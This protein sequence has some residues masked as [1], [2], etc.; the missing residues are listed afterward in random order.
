MQCCKIL[1]LLHQ[2]GQVQ[3]PA[4]YEHPLLGL[5]RS[6]PCAL[7]AAP[8]TTTTSA[9]PAAARTT[10]GLVRTMERGG[11]SEHE[12]CLQHTLFCFPFPSLPYL[13]PNTA[14]LPYTFLFTS[15]SHSQLSPGAKSTSPP[16]PFPA[17]LPALTR[18]KVHFAQCVQL[19]LGHQGL[20]PLLE[21][22]P[23]GG[24]H[25]LWEYWGRKPFTPHA[26][27]PY[28]SISSP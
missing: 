5:L 8:G 28:G 9:A 19:Y 10:V 4:K 21:V 20:D 13:P 16:L 7:E 1:P 23:V 22:L 17:S 12:Q 2:G 6:S 11:A 24:E 14:L 15:L 3:R 26:H 18:G 27:T 25:R